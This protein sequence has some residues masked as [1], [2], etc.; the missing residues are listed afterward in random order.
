MFQRNRK[1]R[2]IEKLRY[3]LIVAHPCSDEEGVVDN[4]VVGESRSFRKTSG[5]LPKK[6]LLLLVCDV[7]I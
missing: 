1:K 3:L 2:Y 5:S 4:I 6:N 7:E